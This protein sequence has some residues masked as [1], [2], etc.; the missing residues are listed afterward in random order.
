MWRT[1]LSAF[2]R[3]WVYTDSGDSNAR[4]LAMRVTTA[5]DFPS[6]MIRHESSNG[7]RMYA[8]WAARCGTV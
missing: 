8:L 1:L 3:V 6:G 4:A 2:E 7:C 5:R